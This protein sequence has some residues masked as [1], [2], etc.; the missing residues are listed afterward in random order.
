M[1]AV[2]APPEVLAGLLGQKK[3]SA[4]GEAPVLYRLMSQPGAAEPE[5]PLAPVTRFR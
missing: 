3:Y 5:A 1:V 4:P 2:E